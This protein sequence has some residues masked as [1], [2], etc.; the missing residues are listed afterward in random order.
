M[1]MDDGEMATILASSGPL[2]EATSAVE[3]WQIALKHA[4][5]SGRELLNRLGLPP[6][7]AGNTGAVEQ[8]EADFPVFV[9]LEFLSRM[10]PGDPLDPLLRQV[11]AVADE[12]R[13]EPGFSGDPVG[14][15]AAEV[16]P[17]LLQKYAGRA[18]LITAGACAIHCRYCFRRQFPY[19]DSPKGPRG[20]AAALEH[21]AGDSSIHEIILSGG[22][23]LMVPDD[24]LA[25]LL[26]QL[27]QIP[28]LTRLRIHSRL[29]VVV[30]QRIT[31]QLLASLEGSRLPVYFVTHINHAREVDD[32]VAAALLGL[33]KS[34]ATLLNQAVWLR[35]V[36]D[37]FAA[38]QELC[39]RLVDLGV[40]PYYLHQL[41]R[42]QG[43]GHFEAPVETGR[44]VVNRLRDH[45][46]GYAVPVFVA[47]VAGDRS[48]RP[49]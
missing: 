38:Q 26:L 32:A 35:G 41:D 7:T 48:K 40:V 18:L 8:A 25:W 19:S 14:D 28:H 12:V 6:E 16:L 11:L 21:L 39:R 13:S 22:D 15:L 10:R 9:P 36:N 49:L 37:S 43:A 31:P 34:G 3:N 24:Q 27:A 44:L 5:R 4:V 2:V 1:K 30:P 33:R 47:E 17:G 45:L 42:V 29:P 23:P 46:P 20:W